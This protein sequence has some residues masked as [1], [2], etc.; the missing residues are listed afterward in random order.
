[1]ENIYY[2]CA[3]PATFYYAWQVDAMLLSFKKYGNVDLTKV[4]IVSSVNVADPHPDLNFQ[5]VENKWKEHGVVFDYYKD[6]RGQHSYISSIRPHI[7]K[8]HWQKYPWLSENT[9]MY[10]DCDIAL[11]KPIE[12]GDMLSHDN[13]KKCYVSDTKS[14][15]G[16]KYI[17]SKG[18]RIL[19][20]M[21]DIVGITPFEVMEREEEA[22]GAQYLLKPGIDAQF[23]QK[24]YE[25]S[26][27]LFEKISKR[28]REIKKSKPE[29]HE[30]Q[31]WC[32]DMWGVLWNLWKKGYETPI[33][34]ILE[35]AWGTQSMQNWNNLTIYHNAGVTKEDP[36][37]PFYKGKYMN[38]PPVKAPRPG[39]SWASQKYY[40]LVVDAWNETEYSSLNLS[41]SQHEYF[42][43]D[44]RLSVIYKDVY[45]TKN[46]VIYLTDEEKEL[47]GVNSWTYVGGWQPNQKSSIGKPTREIELATYSRFLW[48]GNIGHALFD[49]LYPI[50][51][52]FL[53]TGH[54]GE[55]FIP[56]TDKFDGNNPKALEAVN[57]FSGNSLLEYTSLENDEV[58]KIKKLVVGIPNT[59][60]IVM[61]PDRKLWGEEQLGAMSKFRSR[62]WNKLGIVKQH[63]PIPKCA[64]ID[65]KRFSDKDKEELNFTRDDMQIE[66]VNWADFLSFEDQIR[67]LATLDI[68]I[69]GPGN[70]IMYTPLMKPKAT[71]INLGWLE[72][73]QSNTMRPNIVIEET[74][75]EEHEFPA[76][77]EQSML[78]TQSD[79]NIIY[80]DRWE[81]PNIN[82][83]VIDNYLDDI[84]SKN[85][86][87]INL[88]KDGQIYKKYCESVENSTEVARMMT[89]LALFPEFLVNEHP[90]CLKSGI[91]DLELLRKIRKE[92]NYN[93]NWVIQTKKTEKEPTVHIA[94]VATNAYFT[95]G[96]RF[97]RQFH[98]YCEEQNI[99][100]HF[101][102]DTDPTPY[103]K[104]G[105]NCQYYPE[106]HK[107]WQDAT[108]SKF[109]NMLKIEM[110]EHDTLFYFDADTSVTRSFS[111]EWFN[112]GE[113]V[114][115][116]HYGNRGFLSGNK[117]YD[118]NPKSK[119]YIPS[120]D[121]DDTCT[122]YYGAFFGGKKAKVRE[123]LET[124]I[125][126]QQ[127]DTDVL[128]YEPAVNDESYINKYFHV[129]HPAMVPTHK[130]SFN[131]SDKGN[132]M[133]DTRIPVKVGYSNLKQLHTWKEEDWT[134]RDG[135]IIL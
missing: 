52:A 102:S 6:T 74:D 85:N 14:Y 114:G 12:F 122:Y 129:N 90:H 45:L 53:N 113:L 98:I 125:S 105:M 63:N 49:G 67:Y 118:R 41:N 31:I 82:R 33:H 32:A 127:Y 94:V 79:L 65:N 55:D 99:K 10:H 121:P 18:H 17:A 26:E 60:N 109:K 16:G 135:Q 124:L 126:W 58:I 20:E 70:A 8:K 103:L 44:D 120:T 68:Q 77:M 35:F 110:D 56:I 88:A 112:I 133:T 108:N 22:G 81:C 86:T 80:Y 57:K 9:I 11:T 51:C 106:E 107:S 3:Q 30:I 104:S 76:F 61:S 2:I 119:A 36:G 95:L 7:L 78:N 4:H 73:T 72:K 27:N 28:V 42:G 13:I 71:C 39:D 131:I 93:E 15:I 84:K 64:I 66:Y 24:V 89:D 54:H 43:D 21:C 134:I 117:G 19:E 111:T 101:F 97:I 29:W 83:V 96:L 75:F 92:Y 48:V 62:F 91:I 69:S 123:F 1:M 46:G 115:G 100:Y 47:K 50:W 59:G 132:P 116:E 130:F 5:K 25:D 34:P 87:G 128:N 37:K 40:D 23:W 38:L